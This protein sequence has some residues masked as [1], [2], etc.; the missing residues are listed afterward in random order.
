MD[1]PLEHLRTL[2]AVIDAG[3][4]DRAAATLGITPSAVSQRIRVIEQRVG[5]VVLRRTKPV[6]ATEAGEPLVRLARQLDLL[7]HDARSALGADAGAAHV[8]LAVN[9]DS[10]ITWFLPA[11]TAVTAAHAV[12]FELHR[13]DQER[14]AQ[15]LAAGTVMA[16]VTSQ[17]EPV[18][19]CVASPLGR[20][21]YTAVAERDFA[22]RWF[23]D[24]LDRAALE[25][26]PLVDFDRH[27]TLQSSFAR[28]HGARRDAPR[29]IISASAEFAEAV[30]MGLGW[31][32]LLPGQ[33]ESGLAD[34]SL[35][36]LADDTVDIPLYWQRWN[37]SSTLLDTV[38][39][40]VRRTA[41]SS[42]A[43]V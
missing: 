25:Q 43:L 39:D 24:G 13:E 38:T 23:A 35:V 8:P 3:T 27:D 9:A 5:R 26:A 12:T 14:T 32:M 36:V 7:E 41:A 42:P 18:A 10:L 20:M 34:G 11:L 17:R 1:L 22:D 28:R 15:L 40:A 6:T 4:L 21:R 29:H 37:L 31:G 19:G 16:A 30:R 33:F 2:A